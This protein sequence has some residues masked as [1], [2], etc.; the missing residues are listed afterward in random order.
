MRSGFSPDNPLRR[1]GRTVVGRRSSRSAST[2]RTVHLK[3]GDLPASGA[4]IPM[5]TCE[6]LSRL[7]LLSTSLNITLKRSFRLSKKR[8]TEAND[9]QTPPPSARDSD[10]R[11]LQ[12]TDDDSNGSWRE[13]RRTACRVCR[14]HPA[15]LTFSCTALAIVVAVSRLS[16]RRPLGCLGMW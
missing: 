9:L 15:G 16:C 6:P 12:R 2:L 14:A 1:A 4:R 8:A 3:C 5:R 7:V 10:R 13:S 11:T